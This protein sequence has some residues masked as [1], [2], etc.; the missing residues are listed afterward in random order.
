MSKHHLRH[1]TLTS[2]LLASAA[3]LLLLGAEE[4]P[5]PAADAAPAQAPEIQQ[6]TGVADRPAPRDLQT[7]LDSWVF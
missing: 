5:R 4:A 2:G 3:F 7:R 6:Q 1:L